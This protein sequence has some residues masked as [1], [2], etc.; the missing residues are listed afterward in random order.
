MS[1]DRD[2][3]S[4]DS[5]YSKMP[6]YALPYLTHDVQKTLSRKLHIQG[7][8]SLILLDGKTGNFISDAGRVDVLKSYN[9]DAAKG[10]ELIQSWKSKEAVPLDQAKFNEGQ[11]G[12]GILWTIISYFLRN[13]LS[14]FAIL[15]V[16]NKFVKKL[17]DLGAEEKA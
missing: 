4:Y 13:P 7:I 2:E 10:K 15:Y 3:S 1:S 11:P 9:G 6:W 14:I 8:P 12:G 16:Y 5:Y 17:E